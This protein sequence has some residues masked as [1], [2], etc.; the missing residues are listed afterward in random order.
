[1]KIAPGQILLHYRLVEK[2]G[3]GG[4]GVVWKAV[5]TT[6][7]RE[8]AVK[9]LPESLAADTE[10]LQRFEREA[11][12]LASL[13]HPNVATVHGFHD[14]DG[15]RFLVMELVSGETLEERLKRGRMAADEALPI[16]RKIVEGIEYAHER[17][18]V[19]RDL[20]PANIKLT[21]D[22]GVKV[23]D[24]GLA[25]AIAGDA[26]SSG[27][28]ST[29]TVMPTLTSMGTVAGMILGTAAYMS[30]EQ[31]RGG[32]IDRRAD[33]WAFGAVLFEMLTGRRAFE[34]D[35]VSDTLASVLRAPMEW[36]L[37]SAGTPP[38]VVRLLKRCLERDPK[39]RLR[40][41]GEARI[42]LDTA[43]S[44]PEV[45]ARGQVPVPVPAR[46]PWA[47]FAAA[48]IAA[49][50]MGGLIATRKPPEAR[51]VRFTVEPG[52][53][54]TRIDWP[55]LSPD[56]RLLAFQGYDVAGKVAIWVRPVDSLTP[57]PL[58]GTEGMTGRPFWSPDSRY[59]AYFDGRQLKKIP[60]AGGPPQLIGEAENGADGTWGTNGVIVFDG[61]GAVDP[62]RRISAAGG[63]ATPA[64]TG[65]GKDLPGTASWP[66][67]LPDGKHFLFMANGGGGGTGGN[68][69]AVAVLDKPG[70]KQLTE[71]G[72]RVEYANGC[73]VYVLHGTLVAQRFD[74]DRLALSGDPIPLADHVSENSTRALFSVSTGGAI[75]YQAGTTGV[76]SE[77]VWLDRTGKELGK[78]GQPDA[79]G[80]VA[81]A[82]DGSRVAYSLND[83]RT[84]TRDV[85]VRD[86]ARDTASR[87]TFDPAND[88]SA[89][90]SP[91]GG[92]ILFTTTR[93]GY[94]NCMA[95]AANGTGDEKLV[96]KEDGVNITPRDVSRDGRW[97]LLGR[98]AQGEQPGTLVVSA[99]GTGSAVRVAGS[100]SQQAGQF[101]PDGRFIAYMSNET[102]SLEIYVQT[103][104]LG[105]GKWQISN[106]GGV[107]PRWRGDGKELFYRNIA[108]EFY[109]VPVTLEPRFAAGIPKLLFKRRVQ[110][111]N[112]A[113]PNFAMTQDG[114]KF[115]VNASLGTTQASPFTI[116]L[117]WPESLTQH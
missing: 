13:N 101:S 44:E 20:K 94:A 52:D 117:N 90:W 107:L 67:F 30:P 46:L 69:I 112:P 62:V 93:S 86:L 39:K 91:D 81:L 83:A 48:A 14:A 71:T 10:R 43:G 28:T 22:G 40:D 70:F 63:K 92:L 29:P 41:I 53:K 115:L 54:L 75:A 35:T 65:T 6:L 58:A 60:V 87:L 61:R 100:G 8:V 1:M 49:I 12:V 77:L 80:E 37:L 17:G 50:V 57:Y 4:M 109:A 74:A 76:T 34:G 24:F 23:L 88:Y 72:S 106:G 25:K 104:P 73:I 108:H 31:A 59:L 15:V 55:R 78:V 102:G 18:I 111:D 89:V 9:I 98:F 95:K 16:A 85:W 99:D 79:Y 45:D 36:E 116:V 114:Q 68:T 3:E 103:W 42:A 11:K 105:G 5:D 26:S 32:T 38:S 2:I 97:L 33:I 66:F 56:G 21:A 51:V 19:H 96:Y 84:E 47:L 7:D 82:L 113:T 27:P 64:F 110:G